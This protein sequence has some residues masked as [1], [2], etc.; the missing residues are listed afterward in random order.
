[1]KR[2]HQAPAHGANSPLHDPAY[3]SD[4]GRYIE[5]FMQHHPEELRVQK[6]GWDIFWDKEVDFHVWEDERE[7]SVPTPGYYYFE[8]PP[9]RH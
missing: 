4:F 6:E 2:I 3:V 5:D 7:D 9:P 1:M 8:L